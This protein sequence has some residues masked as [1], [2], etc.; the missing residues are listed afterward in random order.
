MEYAHKGVTKK[1]HLIRTIEDTGEAHIYVHNR[2]FDNDL[3]CIVV[4]NTRHISKIVECYPKNAT[5]LFVP[6]QSIQVYI[7]VAG[8]LLWAGVDFNNTHMRCQYIRYT[9]ETTEMDAIAQQLLQDPGFPPAPPARTPRTPR[10]LGTPHIPP[11]TREET[12]DVEGGVGAGGG[13]GGEHNATCHGEREEGGMDFYTYAAS[14]KDVKLVDADGVEHESNKLLLCSHSAVWEALFARWK[15]DMQ[16]K[17]DFST[18]VVTEVLRAIN[19]PV[20]TMVLSEGVVDMIRFYQLKQLVRRHSDKRVYGVELLQLLALHVQ[21]NTA[22]NKTRYIGNGLHRYKQQELLE[23]FPKEPT[24]YGICSWDV[25]SIIYVGRVV[26]GLDPRPPW[27]GDPRELLH[28]LLMTVEE[29]HQK[30]HI[31]L[32]EEQEKESDTESME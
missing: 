23:L 22:Y 16:V 4:D 9:S 27:M 15:C 12:A 8:L 19:D 32:K 10:T 3:V 21:T 20:Y 28:E 1:I 29:Y 11:G 30:W 25:K 2:P 17:V 24:V 18:S 6:H 26:A 31:P 5:Y 7:C 13:G 14:V